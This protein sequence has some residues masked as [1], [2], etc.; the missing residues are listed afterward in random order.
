MS[1]PLRV[2]YPGA[3]YHVLNRGRRR[4][5]IF[6]DD[7]DRKIF[8]KA[9]EEATCLYKL[10]VHCYSLMSNH[11]HLLVRTPEGNLSRIMRHINGVYTQKINK[12][13]N[14]EGS[15]FKGR[16]KSILVSEKEYLLELIRYIHKN[17]LKAGIVKKLGD[18]QWTSHRAY[19]RKKDR[20]SWLKVDHILR[21]FGEYEK[22]ALI[23]MDKFIKEETSDDL[24]KQLDGVKWPSVLGGDTFKDKVKEILRGKKISS[25]DVPEYRKYEVKI[26]ITDLIDE[27]VK[28]YNIDLNAIKKKRNP[29]SAN[30]KRVIIYVCRED[31]QKSAKEICEALGGINRS[32]VTRQY[33]VVIKNKNVFSKDI[34]RVRLCIERIKQSQ[35]SKT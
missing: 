15:I 4:E 1:R 16:Y 23:K 19:M 2:E 13:H 6:F 26:N 3:W 35:Q 14:Y 22:E 5:E 34:Q 24:K 29:K 21:Q 17:P 32:L 18:H 11:Y 7:G 8:F 25:E 30:I 28:E 10:E 20:P 27:I 9:I 33:E 31:L 12:K